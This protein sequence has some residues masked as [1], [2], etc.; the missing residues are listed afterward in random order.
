MDDRDGNKITLEKDSDKAEALSNFFLSV[1]TREP[2]ENIP[3]P[4]IRCIK[5]INAPKITR[6]IVQ[7]KLSQLNV[8]KSLGPDNLHPRILSEMKNTISTPLAKIFNTLLDTGKLPLE[9]KCANITAI[10]KKGGKEIPG[11]YRPISLTS[12]V[13]KIMESNLIYVIT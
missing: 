13:G 6:D 10:Y 3:A 7:K 1:F 4:K 5:Q 12:I 9:W 8:S 11:N 2:E